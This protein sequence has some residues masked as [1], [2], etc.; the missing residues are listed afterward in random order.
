MGD[1]K[2]FWACGGHTME[3]AGVVCG[4][5]HQAQVD[6]LK[7]AGEQLFAALQTVLKLAD[8]DDMQVDVLTAYEI[9]GAKEEW[10]KTREQP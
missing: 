7:A 6:K 5:C 3:D 1:V 10:A 4:I 8:R 9:V 2:A